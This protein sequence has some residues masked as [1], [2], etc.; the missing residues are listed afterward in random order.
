[1]V[2]CFLIVKCCTETTKYLS[3]SDILRSEL[4]DLDIEMLNN[5]KNHEDIP[6][7]MGG[8]KH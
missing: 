4:M 7:W 3:N 5:G 6:G 1:M 2:I 8:D